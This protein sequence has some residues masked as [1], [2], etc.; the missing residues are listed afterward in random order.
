MT[1]RSTKS[2]YHSV[3]FLYSA[4]KCESDSVVILL[5]TLFTYFSM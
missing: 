4:D 5:R 3:N 2:I 1:R